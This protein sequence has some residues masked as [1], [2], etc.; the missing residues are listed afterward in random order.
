MKSIRINSSECYA[1]ISSSVRNIYCFSHTRSRRRARSVSP[2]FAKLL[3]S[4]LI[5]TI[6]G[7]ANGKLSEKINQRYF[8]YKDNFV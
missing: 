4:H 7:I 5:L 6:N 2:G 3:V 8:Q 1:L